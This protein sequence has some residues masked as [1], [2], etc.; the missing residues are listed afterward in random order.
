MWGRRGGGGGPNIKNKERKPNGID[1]EN[2]GN[3]RNQRKRKNEIEGGGRIT[4]RIEENRTTIDQDRTSEEED[5]CKDFVK[6]R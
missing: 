2:A 4:A 1:D 5:R 6:K 3:L